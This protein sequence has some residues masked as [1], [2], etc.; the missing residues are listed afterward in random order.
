MMAGAALEHLRRWQFA[1]L[2]CGA[3][4]LLLLPFAVPLHS[5]FVSV[6]EQHRWLWP[7]VLGTVGVALLGLRVRYTSALAVL[8]V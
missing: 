2:C 6:L 8:L 4:V 7:A 5:G 3:T 1:A